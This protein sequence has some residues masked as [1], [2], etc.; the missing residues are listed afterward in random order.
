MSEVFTCA[1]HRTC[2]RHL[3]WPT[4]AGGHKYQVSVGPL[5]QHTIDLEHD[6][7]SCKKW[8]IIGHNQKTCKGEIGANRPIRKPRVASAGPPLRTP[9]LQVMRA[10]DN[11]TTTSSPAVCATISSSLVVCATSSS[12]PFVFIHT[13][14]HVMT[15][16]WM[17]YSQEENNGNQHLSQS[18]T[19]IQTLHEDNSHCTMAKKPRMV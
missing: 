6:M 11:M 3:C 2:V 18:S 8:D 5:N 13:P 1:E 17:P 12:S 15:I 9:K 10:T 16:R 19:V 4:Y 14:G 7:Y